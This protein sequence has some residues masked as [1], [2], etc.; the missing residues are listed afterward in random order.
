MNKLEK[1]SSNKIQ[2]NELRNIRGGE[3]QGTVWWMESDS[4]SW[5]DPEDPDCLDEEVVTDYEDGTSMTC[6]YLY[7]WTWC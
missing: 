2:R 6:T 3:R 5:T 4:V 1:I 7:C